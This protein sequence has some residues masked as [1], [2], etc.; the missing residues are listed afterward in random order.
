M[1]SCLIADFSVQRKV[2]SQR[3]SAG[4]GL[5]NPAVPPGLI[6]VQ[7][8]SYAYHHTLTCCYARVTAS[9]ILCM[10]YEAYQQ[11]HISA[12]SAHV[13]CRYLML[14]CSLSHLSIYSIKQHFC[15]PSEVHSMK[16]RMPQSH[17]LQLSLM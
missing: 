9:P 6:S 2:L 11:N 3:L 10:L 5:N 1:N 14:I 16:Y 12:L 8:S 4:T 17:R 7:I 13:S 15:L